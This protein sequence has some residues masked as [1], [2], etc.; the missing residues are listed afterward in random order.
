MKEEYNKI[1]ED[2]YTKDQEP[3]QILN[4]VLASKE[5]KESFYKTEEY[6]SLWDRINTNDKENQETLD[7]FIKEVGWIEGLSDMSNIAIF[8]VIQHSNLEYQLKYYDIIKEA[9]KDKKITSSLFAM[10]IDRVKIREGKRQIFGTQV[11]Q[12]NELCKAELLETLNKN[13]EK[14]GL[15]KI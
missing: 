3:R 15:S 14:I 10:F 13:R 9:Y 5:D 11:N 4:I 7:K 6:T 12:N 2:L 1:L 8:L